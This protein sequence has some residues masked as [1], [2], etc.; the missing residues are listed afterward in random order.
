MNFTVSLFRK[1]FPPLFFLGIFIAAWHLVTLWAK[2]PAYLLPTPLEVWEA[3]WSRRADLISAVS[4]TGAEAA[5]GFLCS[6]IVGTIS[7]FLL[8]QSRW[9]RMG[10]YPY[11]IFLQTVPII[12]IAPLIVTWCGT[13]FG[14]VCLVA[15]IVS[16]FP[17]LANATSGLLSIEPGLEELFRLHGSNRWNR[18]VK[19]Q[20]P[21]AVPSIITGARTASGAAVIGAIVGEFFAGYGSEH[22]GLGYFI[23]MTSEQLK[24]SLLFACVLASTCLGIVIFSAVSFVGSHVLRKWYDVPDEQAW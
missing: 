7:A 22:F 10:L 5:C 4:L 9:L 6:L 19:L 14:S 12:A 23:R 17:I 21:S 3:G 24:T 1:V 8:A 16:V 20:L 18:L 13:G 15:F 11:A 2:I